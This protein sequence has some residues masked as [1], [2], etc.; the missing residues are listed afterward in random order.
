MKL[1]KIDITYFRCFE[2]LTVRLHPDINVIVG[3]NGSGKSSILDAIAI[4]LYEIVAANG[5][6]GKSQRK[7]QGAA[8]QATDIYIDPS[9]LNA[10]V[11]R[12]SFVQIS[13]MASDY[14]YIDDNSLKP[15]LDEESVLEWTEHIA[16]RPPTSFSYD[17][18]TSER[19]SELHRYITHLWEE[20][21]KSPQ[22][23][24]PLPVVAY[25][26]A[27]RRMGGMPELGDIFKLDL[28]RDKAFVSALDAAANFT[29]MCQWF[30]LRENAEL[31][32][33]VNAQNGDSR[34]FADLQAVRQALKLT[35]E[36][37]ERV[38]F[39]GSPPRLMVEIREFD[40]NTRAFELAQ[41]SD[42]YRNLL[43]LVLDFAR[44]LAQANPNWP[45]PLEAPGVLLIDE[46]EL[47]LH[48]RWQQKV[49]PALRAAFPNTQLIVSTHSPAVLTTVRREHIKLLGADHQFE[50]IPDDVG[51]YG[52][53]NSR[54]LAEVF[55]TYPRPQNIDIVQQ[56]A[57]YWQAVEAQEHDTDQAKALRKVL[58]SALGTSDPDL[59]RADL[60]IKQLQFLKQR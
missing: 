17:T 53:D 8:L 54:V 27:T 44:R 35:I 56:L 36:G 50:Q 16:Y 45:N 5:G 26:R 33:N 60:R 46:I 15:F 10:F 49:I 28:A 6:G 9:V 30:Y 11:S 39:D 13:A 12:K 21:R 32:A 34:E 7:M 23:L 57:E 25:Y 51:T 20:I 29:A 58:E 3:A 22:A 43:A 55:G 4:A 31:R 19:V 2:S 14:Y 37:L 41:L 1:A 18:S 52:A 42:G 47:H 40:G 48:P 24:I 59:L 38:Y